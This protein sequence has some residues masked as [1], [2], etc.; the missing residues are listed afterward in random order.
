MQ[1]NG[2]VTEFPSGAARGGLPPWA[3]DNAE[4]TELE[5]EHVFRPNWLLVCHA[6]EIPA[7]GDYKCLDALDE[8]AIV[9]R[10]DDGKIRAFHNLCRHR[11]S[12]V[13]AE[14]R[15]NCG[16]VITCPFHGWCYNLDGSL[17]GVP[18]PRSF[19][20]LDKSQYGLKPV[21]FEVWMGLVFVRFK[22]GG[23]SVAEMA[24]PFAEEIAPYRIEE[25][26][27]YARGW[28]YDFDLDWKS[29]VDVDNEGY[30]VP[31]AHPSLNDL[32][33]H[34]YVDESLPGGLTRSTGTFGDKPT[35]LWSVRH[36]VN[37]LPE[38]PNLPADKQ[39]AWIYYGFFPGTVI[40]VFPDMIEYYQ[41]LPV[42]QGQARMQGGCAA[43]R[44]ARREMKLARYLNRRIN[45]MTGDEDIQ[46]IKWAWEGM[47]SSA[48]DDIILSDREYGV[49]AHH[50]RLRQAL[51]VL[52]LWDAPAPG[53]V[54]ERNREMMENTGPLRSVQS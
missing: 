26:E 3:Y 8:R 36:Y 42:G 32:Y 6:G 14:K 23:P 1:K 17:R 35:K 45:N 15:G 2:G 13:V 41:T 40:T 37:L 44:D 53:T 5:K 29:I 34:T 49:R 43:L 31:R 51:P 10:G 9:V 30:H 25:M 18:M 54:A 12:R 38:V 46:L 48:F 20:G 21:E 16:K 47:K 50:D 4:L 24:A 19:P 7:P 33:G 39:K 27:P 11:G 28:R 52:D 22:S